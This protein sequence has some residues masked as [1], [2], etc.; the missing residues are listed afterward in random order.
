MGSCDFEAVSAMVD[1]E[2]SENECDAVIEHLN[3]CRDCCRLFE[4][5]HTTRTLMRG[6]GEIVVP[7]GF[8]ERVAAAIAEEAPA[9]GREEGGRAGRSASSRGAF[10]AQWGWLATAASVAGVAVA[11]A[12]LWSQTATGPTSGPEPSSTLADSGAS[13][14]DPAE[15]SGLQTASETEKSM[16]TIQRYLPEHSSLVPSGPEARFQRTS[17]EVN[18]R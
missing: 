4:R 5:F 1:G 2:L 12:L 18:E 6:E 13:A 8:C 14:S 7:E 10:P 16:A 17:L 3:Q 11:G 15:P 9:A